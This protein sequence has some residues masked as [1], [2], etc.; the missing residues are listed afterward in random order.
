M[1]YYFHKDNG[2]ISLYRY[3][4]CYLQAS[5]NSPPPIPPEAGMP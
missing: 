3:N 4:M 5:K 1:E 2:M